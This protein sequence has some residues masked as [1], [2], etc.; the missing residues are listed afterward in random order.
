[1]GRLRN[2]E[3]ATLIGDHHRSLP[4][5]RST[6]PLM[7]I[8]TFVG[9]PAL[10]AALLWRLAGFEESSVTVSA[11]LLAGA[12]VLGGLLFQV[13]AWISGRLG[14]LG[15]TIVGRAPTDHELGL[16]GRL[17]IARANIA[18]ASLVSVVFVAELGV[19]TLW[20]NPPTW[21]T[22]VS[23][24]LLLHLC[25]TLVLVLVRINRIGKTDRVAALTAHARRERERT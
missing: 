16:V 22:F 15:D 24:F 7:W 23:A 11:G 5:Y 10:G 2:S 12:G 13:L 9:L 14:A 4:Y 17:D 18:Y 1:M 21:T 8:G 20:R 6:G 25:L 3:V 19:V